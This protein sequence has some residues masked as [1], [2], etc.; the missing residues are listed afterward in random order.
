MS[1]VIF[2]N[3]Q[4]KVKNLLLLYRLQLIF[5]NHTV[6]GIRTMYLVLRTY[7]LVFEKNR[8]LRSCELCRHVV[9]LTKICLF[10]QDSK[11][12]RM[13]LMYLCITEGL[14]VPSMHSTSCRTKPIYISHI[15]SNAKHTLYF[16]CNQT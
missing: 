3:G 8:S 1:S 11:F 14:L 15:L 12:A 4:E 2:I 10:H 9:Y 7:C 6:A 16:I 5:L 13:T